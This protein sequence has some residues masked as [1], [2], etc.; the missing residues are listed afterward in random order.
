[1]LLWVLLFLVGCYV[2]VLIM[3]LWF[4]CVLC[5][6]MYGYLLGG[7]VLCWF[8]VGSL[9]SLWWM[10]L[11]CCCVLWLFLFLC[12]YCMLCDCWLMWNCF[13]LNVVWYWLLLYC[14]WIGWFW[15]CWV[16][17]MWFCVMCGGFYWWWWVLYVVYVC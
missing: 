12:R 15:V 17:V 8:C 5:Y 13:V 6:V 9:V 10:W 11:V 7:L 1:M 3:C 16:N 14:W 2:N 4:K